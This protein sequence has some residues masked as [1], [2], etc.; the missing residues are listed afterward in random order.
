MVTGGLA[1]ELAFAAQG[2]ESDM[3]SSGLARELAFAAQ[4]GESKW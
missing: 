1:R 3:V 4:G 2:R